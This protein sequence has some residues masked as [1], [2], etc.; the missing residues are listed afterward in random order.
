MLNDERGNMVRVAESLP[1]PVAAPH[2]EKTIEVRIHFFTDNMKGVPEGQQRPKH[3]WFKGG[4]SL[5]ANESHGLRPRTVH[6]HGPLELM[7]QLGALLRDAG[8]KFHYK[9]SRL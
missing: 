4:I 7:G 9:G 5:V 2:G 3:A 6:F 1:E 8:V